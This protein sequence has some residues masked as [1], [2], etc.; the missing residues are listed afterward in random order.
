[1]SRI[2]QMQKGR[3]VFRI[4]NIEIN[5]IISQTLYQTMRF[6]KTYRYILNVGLHNKSKNPEHMTTRLMMRQDK[7]KRLTG[8]CNLPL[9]TTEENSI[10]HVTSV[11]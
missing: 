4:L 9:N 2:H 5:V 10:L 8:P 3:K 6:L 1:M 7:L 11:Y